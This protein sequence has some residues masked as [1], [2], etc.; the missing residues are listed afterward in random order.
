[1]AL[2]GSLTE[3]SLPDVIQLVS[4][5]GKTGSFDIE[6]EGESG[7]IYLRERQ[8]LYA[9]VGNLRGERAVHIL[10]DKTL[11]QLVDNHR[12]LAEFFPPGV[13]EGRPLLRVFILFNLRLLEVAQETFNAC[14][15]QY[16]AHGFGPL[17]E[18]A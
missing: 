6:K 18:A 8:I 7:K 13:D 5:S 3:L 17:V 14:E 10:L 11:A 2:Q 15:R 1:M 9:E 4:V 16:A 12:L